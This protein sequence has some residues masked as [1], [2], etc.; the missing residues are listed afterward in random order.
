MLYFEY[1]SAITPGGLEWDPK[2]I[3]AQRARVNAKYQAFEQQIAQNCSQ[4]KPDRHGVAC[5]A[6]GPMRV[7]DDEQGIDALPTL[8]IDNGGFNTW[9][10][11]A[12]SDFPELENLRILRYQSQEGKVKKVVI[13]DRV[14]SP[15]ATR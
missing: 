11:K 1:M 9:A 10:R 6:I 2:D 4:F 14:K 3:L 15:S 12:K 5:L 7:T 13:G 8:F